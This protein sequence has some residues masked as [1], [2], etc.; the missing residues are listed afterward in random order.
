MTGPD[1]AGGARRWWIV[2]ALFAITYGMATPLAAYGVFLPVFEETFGWSR[3]A[4]SGALSINLVIGGVAGLVLGA[5]ADRYGPGPILACTVVLAGAGY[6]L[7][8]VVSSLWQ[9]YLLVGV[10]GGIG[11][12]TF[13][14]LSAMTIARWFDARRG[15]ALGLVLMGF[16]LGYITTGPIAAWLIGQVGWRGAY[17]LIGGVCGLL[18][19]GAALTVRL[20]RP[21]EAPPAHAPAT[22]GAGP[23]GMT[24][25]EALAD[26]RQWYLNA[27][28]LLQGALAL[29]ISVHA[30]PYARDLGL[31]LG[32]AALALTGY[33]IGAVSGRLTAGAVSDRIGSAATI[34]AAFVVQAIALA[35]LLG[36]PSATGRLIAIV[37]LGFGLAGADTIIVRVMPDVFGLRSLGAIMGVL[38]FGWR[39]GAAIG[40]TTAGAIHDV[41]GSYG[42]AFGAA[43][44]AV[45]LTWILFSLGTARRKRDADGYG[46]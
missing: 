15:L 2:A 12:S 20:P 30:V 44:G 31:S 6:A 22:D 25:R 40:P 42:L 32:L 43:P 36:W 7:V 14:V 16:N 23:R 8:S 41:T 21:Q 19:L 24:L 34:R 1:S 38:G 26:P 18:T 17:A 11:M 9:L 3:A 27:A 35:G 46:R 13:Y 5:R 10:L 37:G 33:G 4:I 39:L 28:W 45:A 29:M